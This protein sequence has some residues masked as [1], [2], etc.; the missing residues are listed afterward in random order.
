[1]R[2]A[3]DASPVSHITSDDPPTLLIHGDE[4]HVV[5]YDQSVNFAKK[6]SQAG[7]LSMLIRVPGAGHGP[8]LPG[9]EEPAD[10]GSWAAEW[11]GSHLL[12]RSR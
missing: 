5:P 10:I 8:S 3:R 6:L 1:M 11:F 4:D 9:A 7:L 12:G 2:I